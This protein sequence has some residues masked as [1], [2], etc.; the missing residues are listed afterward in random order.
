[1][2]GHVLLQVEA[3]G[4][5]AAGASRAGS[6]QVRGEEAVQ[7]QPW[8]PKVTL[9]PGGHWVIHGGQGDPVGQRQV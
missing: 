6:C 9:K 7:D 4:E 3:G 5:P 8:V 1:M 2:G